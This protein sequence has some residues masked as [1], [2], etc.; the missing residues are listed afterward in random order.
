MHCCANFLCVWGLPIV[1]ALSGVGAAHAVTVL[2][3]QNPGVYDGVDPGDPGFPANANAGFPIGNFDPSDSATA[4]A[5]NGASGSSDNGGGGAAPEMLPQ[6]R[7][8]CPVPPMLTRRPQGGPE[9]QPEVSARPV[10][11]ATPLPL[12]SLKI[13]P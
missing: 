4:N 10:L 8:S 5:G 7:R 1:F 9:A 2:D 11:A 6:R 13:L 12:V 3:P